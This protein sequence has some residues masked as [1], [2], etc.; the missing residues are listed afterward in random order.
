M[1]DEAMPG[2]GAKVLAAVSGGPDSTALLLILT[3]LSKGL[4]FSLHVAYFD[5]GLRGSPT[6][7]REQRFV[8]EL[9]ESLQLPLSIGRADVRAT[10]REQRLSL[11]TAA[12]QERYGFLAATAA[13]TGSS[14][15]ATGHTASD[16]AETVLLNLV[17]GTGVAGLAGMAPVSPWPFPGHEDLVLLRPLLRLSR[18]DTV[19]YCHACGVEPL[20]DESNAYLRHRRNRIRHELLP[21]MREL[22]PRIDEALVRL[23]TAAAD[24]AAYIK[25]SAGALVTESG[26]GTAALSRDL[27]VGAAASLRRNALRSALS[28]VADDLQGFGEAHIRSLERLAIQGHTGDSQDLPR[29]LYAELRRETLEIRS[30]A[31]V[32]EEPL[33]DSAAHLPVPGCAHLGGLLVCAGE[34]PSATGVSV[35]VDA[36]A[37]GPALTVR[38]RRNGDRFQPLGMQQPKKL[39]D[40]FVDSHVPRSKRDSLAIFEAES[41]IAWV[42]GQRIAEWARPRPGKPTV[43]LSCQPVAG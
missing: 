10:A 6:A 24:D 5:H 25:S 37:M 30:R 29:A 12:R 19:A 40:F 31:V 9:A 35:E 11:E 34:E 4:G 32:P 17:R 21:L 42:A 15:V 18:A 33:P 41:G 2:R 13:A 43:F 1:L 22:N 3:R 8:S 7:A 20:D 28:R 26:S 27:L 39:Q 38:R 36:A 23:A 16:Q 14:A